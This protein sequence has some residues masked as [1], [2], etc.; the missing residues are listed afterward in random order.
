MNDPKND[1]TI[2]M[3]PID[4]NL[5]ER[6]LINRGELGLVRVEDVIEILKRIKKLE[7]KKYQEGREMMNHQLWSEANKRERL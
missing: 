5:L 2:E 3:V 4:F 1:G 7:E 6:Q